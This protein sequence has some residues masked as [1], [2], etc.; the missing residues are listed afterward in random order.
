[1]LVSRQSAITL[2]ALGI[3][4]QTHLSASAVRQDP[5]FRATVERVRVD[6]IVTDLEGRF[7]DGLGRD[8]FTLFEDGVE[9]RLTGLLLVDLLEGLPVGYKIRKLRREAA[10]NQ[11]A[12]RRGIEESQVVTP[13]AQGPDH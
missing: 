7:I 8:D 3:L 6:V 13:I 1:M 11:G 9:Q 10:I 12:P 5:Q 2:L 4:I